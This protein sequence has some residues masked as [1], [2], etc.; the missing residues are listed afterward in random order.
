MKYSV[1]LDMAGGGDS[2][3]G[4][5]RYEHFVMDGVRKDMNIT[6]WK[7]VRGQAV[8]GSDEFVDWIY[9]RF[10]SGKKADRRELGGIKELE[11]GP[12]SVE[13]IGKAVSR[14]FG[15][16]EEGLCRSR[17]ISPVRSLLIELYRV[18]LTRGMSLAEI[19]RRLG[20]ISASAIS[21]NK[22]RLEAAL[23]RDPHLGEILLKLSSELRSKAS[24]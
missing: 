23:G 24:Q 5:R 8:L 2:F 15:I 9:E 21:Q 4:R 10:L 7:G 13:E 20:G 19:G 14:E 1:I 6:F 22:K 3:R 17:G 18:H 16:E 11:T 12:R